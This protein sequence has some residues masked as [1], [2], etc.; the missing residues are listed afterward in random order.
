MISNVNPTLAEIAMFSS[1]DAKLEHEK[2][3][4]SSIVESSRSTASSLLEPGERVQIFRGELVDVHGVVEEID[5]DILTVA[6]IDTDLGR[7]SISVHFVCKVFELGDHV[8]VM[9]RKNA[10]ETGLVIRVDENMVTLLG[11]LSMQE[12]CVFCNHLKKAD[13]VGS[14]VKPPGKYQLHDLVQ[15]R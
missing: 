3:D 14:G 1:S 6:P 2:L 11:D 5:Q 8:E 7:Q 12:V 4:F 9:T 15:L 13:H 10:G